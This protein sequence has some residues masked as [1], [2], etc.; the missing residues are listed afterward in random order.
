MM[1][2]SFSLATLYTKNMMHVAAA[3]HQSK[4]CPIHV[5]VQSVLHNIA[6]CCHMSSRSCAL[7]VEHVVGPPVPISIATYLG[8]YSLVL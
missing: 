7:V 1:A 2:I 5:H 6:Q 4:S 8:H 3:T